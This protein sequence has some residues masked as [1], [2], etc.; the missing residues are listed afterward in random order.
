VVT[1]DDVIAARGRIQVAVRRTPLIHSFALGRRLG[2]DTFLKCEMLQRTGSFKLRGA[3]NKLAMLM[4]AERERGVIAASAG[5]HAQGVAVAAAMAGVPAVVVMPETAPHAKIA[6]SREY[7]AEVILFGGHYQEARARAE[8]LQRERGLTM[9]H[10]FDDAAIIAGQGTT[11]LEIADDLAEFDTIIVPVGGGGLISGIAVVVKALVPR[12][13][14]IGVQ[15]EA[16][17]AMVASLA[18]GSPVVIPAGDTLAD[19]IAVER[20]GALPLEIIARYV[21]DV[22]TVGE[23]D[24]RR[25]IAMLLQ[26]AKLLA[27][28]AGAVALAAI[29]ADR[30]PVRDHKVVL[31]LSGGNIDL[32]KLPAVLADNTL[33]PARR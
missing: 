24:I 5:N 12:A 28:G 20:P 25:A 6:A 29:L 23:A 30:V 16:C 11:A 3:V 13:R 22:V 4:P 1:L 17:S 21:D 18:A 19:G 7:G 27:E 32:D 8:Q 10:G 15:A 14:V 33:S 9:I 26:R 31:V 2:C